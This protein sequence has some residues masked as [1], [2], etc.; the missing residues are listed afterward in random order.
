MAK[1]KREKEH[2][3]TRGILRAG[4]STFDF[5]FIA[6]MITLLIIA[7]YMKMDIDSVY[8]DADPAKFIMYKP[9][10]PDDT[11]TFEDLQKLNPDVIGWI[12][13]Y[14]TNID[15]PLL[16]S[17]E[18]NNMYLGH[19]AKGEPQSS[20]SIFIDY[21]NKPDFTDFNTIIHGHHMDQHKMFGDIE[22]FRDQKFFEK[23]E[24]GNLY[25]NN[26]NYGIDVLVFLE[27]DGYNGKIYAPAIE[28]E[29]AKLQYINYC[30]KKAT[31]IRGVEDVKSFVAN[32][33]RTSPI[34]PDDHLLVLSTCA[35]D[36]TNGRMLLVAKLLDH[37]VANPYPK[38]EL[39]KKDYG[40]AEAFSLVE[41][42]GKFP[43]WE[44]ILL[45][46]ILILLTFILYILSR[47]TSRRKGEKAHGKDK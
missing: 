22:K 24:Y 28:G 41:R 17:A 40:T 34:T 26:K 20:G 32:E 6:L 45:L 21:R 39:K 5:L 3:V 33:T 47:K 43:I 16:Y 18:S 4:N 15:Y 19:N 1:V 25:Y 2:R 14:D 10:L 37:H 9:E 12:T 44:W 35:M 31:Y 13:I 27:T 30:Y 29:D 23:H 46:V 8:E 36:K 7:G 38:S 11:E 42:V